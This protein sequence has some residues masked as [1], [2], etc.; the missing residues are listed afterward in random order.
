MI[1]KIQR[2][3]KENKERLSICIV[4]VV[5]H[6]GLGYMVSYQPDIYYTMNDP[7]NLVSTFFHSGRPVLGLIF[8]LLRRPGH[9]YSEFYYSSFIISIIALIF[10]ILYY[11]QI[12][13]YWS[14][15]Y[16]DMIIDKKISIFVSVVSCITVANMFSAEFFLYPNSTLGFVLDIFLSIVAANEFLKFDASHS[17]MRFMRT[18]IILVIAVFTY[19]PIIAVFVIVSTLFTILKYDDFKQFIKSQCFCA[20]TYGIA[21]GIKLTVSRY[22][23]MLERSNFNVISFSETVSTYTPAGELPPVYIFNRITFG[24]WVYLIASI[25]LITLIFSCSVLNKNY[26]YIIKTLYLA[27]IVL[28][29]GVLPFISRASNDYKPRIYYPLGWFFGVLIL[30]GV[31][32]KCIDIYDIRVKMIA[33]I[34]TSVLLLAQWL[35][36]VQMFEDQYVTNYEDKYISKIIGE[37]ID[38][39]EKETSQEIKY[40]SFYSDAKRSKYI[41]NNGW[42]IT[43][44]AY[45]A[46]WSKLPTLNFYLEKSYLGG[47]ADITVA[48]YFG[49]RDWEVFSDKQ[50]IFRGDTVHICTY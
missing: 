44:R 4:F 16:M 7:H 19:E 18:L 32:S 49:S 6:F 8:L 43:Q 14:R 47:E 13:E 10:A 22:I 38:E 15:Y 41:R 34:M 42:C 37:C 17:L 5:A 21:L 28:I 36:F 23:I 25:C 45:D 26:M 2:L 40:V 31:L 33:F 30:Y 20:L 27:G 35:S 29:M 50:I 9:P 11:A 46:T 48:D 12:I 3:I 24:M 1:G 39:Y